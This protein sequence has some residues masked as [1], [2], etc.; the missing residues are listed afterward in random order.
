MVA[1]AIT[2]S[3]LAT[4]ATALGSRVVDPHAISIR[5]G[6]ARRLAGTGRR[7]L[8]DRRLDAAAASSCRRRTTCTS[9]T[10]TGRP[11]PGHAS[12]RSWSSIRRRPTGASS[13]SGLAAR[14]QPRRRDLHRQRERRQ[15][16]QP[17]EGPWERLGP[18]WSP[19]VRRMCSTPTATG[20]RWAGSWSNRTVP[21]SGASGPMPTS[22]TRRGRPRATGSPSWVATARGIRHL[23]HR[24]GRNLRQLTDSVGPDGGPTGRR[25]APASR[26]PRS[27]TT[28][29]T[30]TH[31]IAAPRAISDRTTTC[32]S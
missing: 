19:T 8:T 10:P 5:H 28:A 2:I 21:I 25:T 7:G 14:H 18:D 23:D 24:C 17:H 29:P 22:S 4:R 32:G 20:S 11:R 27:A 12:A 26:S 6:L 9:R 13:S 16:A 3:A 15:R 30:P 31:R 1:L